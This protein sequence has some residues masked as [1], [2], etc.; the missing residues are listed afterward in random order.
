MT[1]FMKQDLTIRLY[2]VGVTDEQGE[3]HGFEWYATK[4][5]AHARARQATS[6]SYRPTVD[7]FDVVPTRDGIVTLLRH[8]A[9]HPDNG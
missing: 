8:V 3:H 5:E 4:A 6:W 2:R 7:L 1:R 9:E